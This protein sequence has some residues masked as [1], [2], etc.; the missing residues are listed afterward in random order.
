[1]GQEEPKFSAA[2]GLWYTYVT[3]TQTKEIKS[4]YRY[5]IDANR[6][7]TLLLAGAG[8]TYLRYVLL[9]SVYDGAQEFS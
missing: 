7:P 2:L 5:Y 8:K 3:P 6:T 9:T 1:M 4:F